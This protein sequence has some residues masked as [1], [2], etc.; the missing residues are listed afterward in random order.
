MISYNPGIMSMHGWNHI[1]TFFIMSQNSK[2]NYRAWNHR[3]WL[4]SYMS[5]SQVLLELHSSRDWAALHVADNSCFH[6]RAVSLRIHVKCVQHNLFHALCF[7][8]SQNAITLN[9][10]S[11]LPLNLTYFMIKC[12]HT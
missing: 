5:D 7:D 6:F 1:Y 9:L 4:V 10:R 11:F 3:C 8:V 12:F 2:M